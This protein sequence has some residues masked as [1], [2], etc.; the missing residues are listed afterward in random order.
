[1]ASAAAAQNPQ[2]FSHELH[3]K[4][5][6]RL[7]CVTCHASVQSSTRREDNNLPQ[8]AI[9]LGCH[10]EASVGQPRPTL[11]ARFNHQKHLVLGNIAPVIRSVSALGIL[12]VL[13]LGGR[14]V[15]RGHLT[16]GAVVA[17]IGYLHL[18]AWPA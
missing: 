13:W 11:L 5:P 12:V 16:I 4:L 18:L 6:A 8:V 17:F 2:P 15:A 7:L 14:Q 1:M 9:C 3:L 10:K